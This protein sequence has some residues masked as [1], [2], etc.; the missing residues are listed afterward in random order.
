MRR[1]ISV[2]LILCFVLSMCAL[3]D[4]KQ[5][6]YPV[7]EVAGRPAIL[8]P[9]GQWSSMDEALGGLETGTKVIAGPETDGS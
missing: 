2:F 7:Y 9:A 8:Y 3:A 1:K 4:S 5:H 6:K